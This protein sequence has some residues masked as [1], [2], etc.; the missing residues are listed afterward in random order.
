[1]GKVPPHYI[2]C[3]REISPERICNHQQ[4]S[5]SEQDLQLAATLPLVEGFKTEICT[6]F[7]HHSVAVA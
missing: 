1:M 5:V 2:T 7:G 6:F 4:P 3:R